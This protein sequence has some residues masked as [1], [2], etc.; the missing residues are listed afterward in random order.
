MTVSLTPELDQFV[1]TQ[2]K[3]GRYKSNSEVVRAGLRALA[4][5]D[6]QI[7]LQ[8]GLEDLEAGSRTEASTVIA[9]LRGR[10]EQPAAR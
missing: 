2:V 3:S 1:E 8:E 9:R 4:N 6:L 7:W 10:V 5:E